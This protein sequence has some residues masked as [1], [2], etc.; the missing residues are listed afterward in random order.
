MSHLQPKVSFFYSL[1][2]IAVNWFF[3]TFYDFST[4][5]TGNIPSRGSAIIASNHVSFYDP[6]MIGAHAHRELSY[7]ARDTLFKSLFGRIIRKL[8]AIPVARGNA[9]IKSLKAIFKTLNNKGAIVIFLEGSRSPDGKI[10]A[11][12]P[13]VGMIACKSKAI[14][15]PTR[16]FGAFE[17]FGRQK[18]LPSLGGPIHVAFGKPI[19]IETIDPGKNHPERYLEASQKITAEVA[20]LKVP[21]YTVV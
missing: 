6:P 5:G 10:G 11:P 7:L 19:K 18:K 8:N 14:I 3:S 1:S 21:A 2:N 12:K 15:I 13:G 9:D 17:V 4:S 20:K 16:V